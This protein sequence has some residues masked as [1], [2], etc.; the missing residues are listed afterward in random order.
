MRGGGSWLTQS[1]PTNFHVFVTRRPLG[2]DES[3]D[4]WREVTDKEK[5]TLEAS[6]AAW[7][8]PE[9]SFVEMWEALT[10]RYGW[11]EKEGIS[12]TYN[13]TTGYF[14]FKFLSP[15]TPEIMREYEMQDITTAEAML[16]YQ[17][18]LNS[19][20]TYGTYYK[21]PRVALPSFNYYTGSG[22]QVTYASSTFVGFSGS[23]I[24]AGQG[25]IKSSVVSLVKNLVLNTTAAGTNVKAILGVIRCDTTVSLTNSKLEFVLITR[26]NGN[27]KLSSPV[28]RLECF[29][30]LVENAINTTPITV[31]VHADV[32]DKLTDEENAEWHA[33]NVAASEKQITFASA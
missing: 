7:V 10:T 8:E 5:Q 30:F 29:E 25:V 15:N 1:Y 32:F 27:L 26:L 3:A 21:V 33:V 28:L 11:S 18:A 2:K 22:A 23:V 4:D 16:I 14:G 19:P 13:P 17:S 9:R 31:T 6:D 20:D 12:L 24:L